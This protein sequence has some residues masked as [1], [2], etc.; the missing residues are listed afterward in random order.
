MNNI[1][2][3]HL[4]RHAYAIIANRDKECLKVLLELIDDSRND[5]FLMID[6]KTPEDFS[7]GL[8]CKKAQLTILPYSERIDIRWGDLSIV[9][10]E[11]KLFEYI[12]N[13]KEKYSYI[14][15]LSGQDLPIKSQDQIHEFFQKQRSGSNFIEI[16]EGMEIEKNLKNKT[17]FYYLFTN[18]QRLIRNNFV[19]KA[20][21]FFF[22]CLRHAF[23]KIQKTIKY[24]RNWED[25]KPVKGSQWVSISEDFAKFLISKKNY[26]LKRFKGVL[27]PDEIYKQTMIVNSP[28]NATVNAVSRGNSN[29]IRYIDWSNS[30]HKGSPKVLSLN[31]WEN[32]KSSSCL[33]ARKFSSDV[34]SEIIEKV[35]GIVM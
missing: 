20:Q 4:L 12:L 21:L 15:L 8:S 23:L 25:L 29:G 7:D 19:S 14:H 32:L 11:L 10:A 18:H 30:N 34:D 22:K 17:D 31:D 2:K 27:I 6:K 13:P 1:Q 9:K 16:S 28:F 33:F 5:I 3:N 26:I 35:K 24:K